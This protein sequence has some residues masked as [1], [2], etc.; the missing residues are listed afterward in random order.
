MCTHSNKPELWGL[1]ALWE[2]VPVNVRLRLLILEQ[3]GDNRLFTVTDDSCIGL[4]ASHAGCFPLG[5]PACT[6]GLLSVTTPTFREL[7]VAVDSLN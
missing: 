5:F 2:T 6:E 1:R 3:E 7:S 4:T